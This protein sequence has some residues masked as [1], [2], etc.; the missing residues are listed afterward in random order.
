MTI[1]D[2]KV[3]LHKYLQTG[4]DAIVWKLDGLSDYAARR[5]MTP[6]GTNILGMIKHLAICEFGYFGTVFGRPAEEPEPWDLNEINSDM[7]ARADESREF[8][9]G[10]YR[11]SWAHADATI[12][13]LD[14]NSTGQVPWWPGERGVVN[15]HRVLIHMIAETNRHAGHADLVRE[16]ID[17]AA[18]LREGGSNLPDVD[19]AWWADY[20]AML[21]RTAREASRA[22]ARPGE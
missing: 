11:R 5:P 15:L 13:A 8:I 6:T 16:L 10:Y 19:E 14:L 1:S 4:R 20:R 2:Q 7:Y 3:D 18:G 12:D 22:T 9:L 21:E 17:G